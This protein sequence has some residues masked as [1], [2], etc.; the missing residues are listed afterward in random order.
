MISLRDVYK[1][2]SGEYA[3]NG[4]SFDV[5][6]R[7]VLG[8]LGPNGAG[9]TTTMRILA[10]LLLPTFGSV[11]IN[12]IDVLKSPLETKRLIGYLPENNPLPHDLK[13]KEYLSFRGRLKGLKGIL[14][15]QRFE[16]VSEKCMIGDVSN[17]LISVLSKGYRQ[18][19]GLADALIHDPEILILD[20]PTVGLDPT[21]IR[22]VRKLIKDIGRKRTVILSTHILPE[23][24]AMCDRIVIIKNG[25]IQAIDTTENLSKLSRSTSKLEVEIKYNT[26]KFELFLSD[27]DWKWTK[28]KKS[29]SGDVLYKIEHSVSDDIREEVFGAIVK[30]KSVVLGMQTRETSLE[31]AFIEIVTDDKPGSEDLA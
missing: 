29:D 14:L 5:A 12:G 31:D 23:V 8:F 13:V 16:Y 7:E 22:K 25:E 11:R 26:E 1:S 19:V 21:Q 17:K 28:E 15:K 24:E 20:E 30:N 4:I 27:S 3:L 9:K 6:D 10:G 2:Y 18:R